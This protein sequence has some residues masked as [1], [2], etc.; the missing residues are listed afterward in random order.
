MQMCAVV[1]GYG[2]VPRAKKYDLMPL[3]LDSKWSPEAKQY[4]LEPFL[5]VS[6]WCPSA[7]KYDYH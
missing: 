3:S 7:K 5:V 2:V 6:K 4:D 1:C